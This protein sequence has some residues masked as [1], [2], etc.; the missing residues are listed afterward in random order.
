MDVMHESS[1]DD[2]QTT[3]FERGRRN[4]S[5]EKKN[6]LLFKQ[7]GAL[8]RWNTLKEPVEWGMY[9]EQVAHVH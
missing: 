9:F 4:F 7:L 2:F 5:L 6:I 8:V 1:P 3:N